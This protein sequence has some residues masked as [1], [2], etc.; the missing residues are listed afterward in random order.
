V[1]RET[2]GVEVTSAEPESEVTITASM[3][4]ADARTWARV[5]SGRSSRDRCFRPVG[6]VDRNVCT[7][8]FAWQ[9]FPDSPIV[10][11]ANRDEALDRP[12]VPPETVGTDPVIL[13]PRD[14]EAGGTWIGV[15]DRDVF[16]AITN[17]WIDADR[18][19]DRSRGLLVRDALA[20][21]SGEA[22]VRYVEDDL[23]ERTYEPFNLVVADPTGALFVEY[24]GG[25][26][27]RTLD[28]G[29]HVVG[30]T[31][32]DGQ[33]VFPAGPARLREAAKRQAD[34]VD[35]LR[36][37]LQPEPGEAAGAWLDRAATAIRD[38]EFGVCVHGDGF[39]TRSSSLLSVGVG[40]V[41]Y[42]YADGPPCETDYR[43]VDAELD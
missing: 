15:S 5:V 14:E 10:V 22:A 18:V 36:A 4:H 28:P 40:G 17:R 31:G 42:R 29:V 25:L 37:H 13:A 6:C 12:S 7:L 9:A 20:C 30:N 24:D 21:E 43:L 23:N 11:A 2:P 38:H 39:G 16:V 32:A 34:N 1:R 35:R 3:D 41:S 26:S 8:V 19:G 27:I 33:Y